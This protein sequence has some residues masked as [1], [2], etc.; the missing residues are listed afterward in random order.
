MAPTFTTKVLILIP[1]RNEEEFLAKTLGQLQNQTFK[2]W[3]AV[4]QDNKSQDKSKEI[5][6]RFQKVDE[7]FKLFR[8]DEE[9]PVEDN[10]NSLFEKAKLIVEANFVCWLGGDDYWLTDQYLSNIILEFS[11]NPE[12]NSV[13]P[14]FTAS[15]PLDFSLSAQYRIN[16]TDKSR[17]KNITN[18][19]DNW[20]NALAIYGVYR[21]TFFSKLATGRQSK[22]SSYEGSD[23]W[24][25]FNALLTNN[26]IE[27]PGSVYVK[28]F[29]GGSNNYGVSGAMKH[30]RTGFKAST[31][32]GGYYTVY[33]GIKFLN[34]R[35][36]LRKIT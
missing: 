10:W 27:S 15:N 12:S 34:S 11:R 19:V 4:A 24:W 13:L 22:I 21:T 26:F 36:K 7:R 32:L 16:L 2:D 5:Y 14:V 33:A 20:A 31:L 8:L 35:R 17:Q 30:L 25:T 23:W 9:I 18:L 28:T 29:K 3:I 1:F 6:Q